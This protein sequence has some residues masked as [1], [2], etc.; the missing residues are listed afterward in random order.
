[1][2]KIERQRAKQQPARRKARDRGCVMSD[3]HGLAPVNASG[4]NTN[5]PRSPLLATVKPA[6]AVSMRRSSPVIPM[7][8]PSAAQQAKAAT[9]GQAGA[10]CQS[11]ST[12]GRRQS[13]GFCRGSGPAR[14]VSTR[15]TAAPSGGGALVWRLSAASRKSSLFILRILID[16]AIE[17]AAHVLLAAHQ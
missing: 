14:R 2:E 9:R 10:N 16:H 3:G 7:T 5:E 12:F 17:R 15:S 4:S 11:S 13:G 8:K 6:S 1:E